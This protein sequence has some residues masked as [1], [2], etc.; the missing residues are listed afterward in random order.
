MASRPSSSN[1][2]RCPKRTASPRRSPSSWIASRPAAGRRWTDGKVTRRC[3]W[4][5]WS[6]T[7]WP[8]IASRPRQLWRGNRL[9]EA[10]LRAHRASSARAVRRIEI[11][12][13][14][15]G[16]PLFELARQGERF[17]PSL[18]A[19]LARVL[20]HGQFILGPEVAELEVGLARYAGVRHAV[21]VSSGRDALIM[22]LMAVGV[23]AG[24]AVFVPAFTF[25][26]TAGAVV[27]AG[28]A[29]VLT[30]IDPATFNMSAEQLDR[31]VA[32]TLARGELR[33]K[34]VI[35]VDLYGLPADYAAIEAVA[36][37]YGLAIVADA[38]Q[39]FGGM[40]GGRRV[41]A[42]AALTAISFYPT[43]PLGGVGDGGAIL[44]N[45]DGLA[46][47]IRQ[48]RSHGTRGSGDVA[49]RLGMTGRLDTLQA[50][51]LLVKLERFDG[52]LAQS[53]RIA[54]R[55]RQALDGVVRTP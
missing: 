27:A 54:A 52:M 7:A 37:K 46:E 43:K 28:A 13:T 53:R 8:S 21:G 3:A 33:P 15:R 31:T 50:A 47:T 26:A 9:G 16:V 17:G 42:L 55:Y 29:P 35:P 14:R 23:G 36:Q 12:N 11:A 19:R 20:E 10:D 49:V 18:A 45:D 41:G 5:R 40:V 34:A 32:R 6:P 39:S 2:S 48:I 1:R 25:S 4:P 30:D 51:V 44:T 22:A 38:A 24:D